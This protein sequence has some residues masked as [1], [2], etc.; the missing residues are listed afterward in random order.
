MVGRPAK[1]LGYAVTSTHIF[2]RSHRDYQI[3]SFKTNQW[4]KLKLNSLPASDLGWN[5]TFIPELNIVISISDGIETLHT[6]TLQVKNATMP[7]QLAFPQGVEAWSNKLYLFSFHELEKSS[8]SHYSKKIYQTGY[9][10]KL[11]RFNLVK[12]DSMMA[13]SS[14]PKPLD[15]KGKFV[16]GKLYLFGGYSQEG[17]SKEIFCYDPASD[18]WQTVGE[19]DRPISRYGIATDGNLIYITGC[20][21]NEKDGYLIVFNPS[22]KSSKEYKTNLRFYNGCVVAHGEILYFFGGVSID[23]SMQVNNKLYSLS[24]NEIKP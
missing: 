16:N 17:E 7:T 8:S 3:Y 1:N 22:N 10:D 6:T 9:S 5:S 18:S 13:C 15:T 14:L 2:A 11:Y 23:N 12:P 24:L 20:R 21:T 4:E 19:L